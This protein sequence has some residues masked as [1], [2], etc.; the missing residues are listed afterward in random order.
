MRPQ[1]RAY[2]L[3]MAA[4]AVAGTLLLLWLPPAPPGDPWLAALLV[5]LGA[6][7]ANFP[8]MVSPRAL[9]ARPSSD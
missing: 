9:P 6:L 5:A 2:L 1:L 3:A 8:V 7:A 4:P